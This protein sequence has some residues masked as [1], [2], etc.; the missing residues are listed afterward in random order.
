MF[1]ISHLIVYDNFSFYLPDCDPDFSLIPII[2]HTQL[3]VKS[4]YSMSLHHFSMQQYFFSYRIHFECTAYTLNCHSIP[5][6]QEA[7]VFPAF[8]ISPS[9]LHLLFSIALLT[10][11]MPQCFL[12]STPYIYGKHTIRYILHHLLYAATLH[13]FHTSW[14]PMYCIS[15]HTSLPVTV[16]QTPYSLWTYFTLYSFSFPTFINTFINTSYSMQ[17]TFLCTYYTLYSNLFLLYHETS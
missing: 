17:C 3:P 11:Y 4:L 10:S 6:I 9:S 7:V 1:H 5:Q 15:L 12:Y 13:I 14:F 8:H 16:F 2:P